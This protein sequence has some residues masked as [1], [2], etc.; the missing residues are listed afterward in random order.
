MKECSVL[1]GT[2]VLFHVMSQILS[3]ARCST[4]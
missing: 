1:N 3:V 4:V 2:T